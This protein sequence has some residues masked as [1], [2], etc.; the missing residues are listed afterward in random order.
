MKATNV[1]SFKREIPRTAPRS[2]P[3]AKQWV[4]KKSTRVIELES[5]LQF[6]S[7]FLAINRFESTNF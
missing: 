7:F 5:A 6:F 2:L 1:G 4:S 3:A